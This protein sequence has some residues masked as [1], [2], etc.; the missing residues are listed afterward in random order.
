MYT[1]WNDN[2]AL[3]KVPIIDNMLSISSEPFFL[4]SLYIKV[5][6]NC[7]PHPTFDVDIVT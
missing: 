2:R 6:F 4:S 7:I 3:V 5:I 1:S